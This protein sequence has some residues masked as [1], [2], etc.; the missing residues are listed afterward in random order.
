MGTY[1]QKINSNYLAAYE[2]VPNSPLAQQLATI[3]AGA[4]Q[5]VS[6]T[7]GANPVPDV[8]DPSTKI[9]YLTKE[10]GSTKTDPYT[11]WIYIAGTPSGTWEVIGET[12]IDLSGYKTVQTAKSDPTASGTA[13]SFI[14]TITQNANGEITATKAN[15]PTASTSAAGIVQL[16]SGATNAATGNHTHTT[17]L[18]AD[19][20]TATVTLAHDTTYKLTAGGTSVIFKT[21]VDSN[22]DEK[23]KATAKTD[24]VNY[25]ILATASASPTSGAATEAVYD[26]DITLNPSTN[27]IAA[28]I[29][30]NAATASDAAANSN[31]EHD[32][33]SKMSKLDASQGDFLVASDGRGE[34]YET[35]VSINE[36]ATIVSSSSAGEIAVIA[37][38]GNY[39]GS[40][41]TISD[42]ATA[43]HTHGDI[44][45][46][47][48]IS[49]SAVTIANGDAVV[50]TDSSASGKVVKSSAS[51]DGSTTTKAL[52][53]KGT[54]ETFY[55]KPSGGIGT[56]DL[57]S[58]VTTSLG[59]ADSAVQ[60]VTVNG[61]SVVNASTKVAAIPTATSSVY[62]VVTVETVTI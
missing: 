57:A 1:V 55:Q 44:N 19:S 28:N 33:N 56:S 11:E 61:S 37:S 45:N 18:A 47:G 9:I 52:T 2:V 29:S 23:V 8:S 26:A 30:G 24:N 10:S 38:D 34:V 25:K 40:S 13:T 36:V 53:Q 3:G 54:F 41:T 6:L 59:K 4:F 58:G 62:G 21:P 32:I 31:L 43:T 22:T 5:V 50:I 42:L 48:T 15:L 39:E 17:T 14:A 60:D 27:T 12:S 35:Q 51:F 16:G 20:G 49:A 46:N 7:T